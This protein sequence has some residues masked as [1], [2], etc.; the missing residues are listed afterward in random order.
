MDSNY[1][2]ASVDIVGMPRSQAKRN[3]L[4]LLRTV[5]HDH[6]WPIEARLAY[7]AE[8]LITH[9]NLWGTP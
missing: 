8:L 7:M 3:L 4:V 6:R 1:V 2:Q 5:S 9:R